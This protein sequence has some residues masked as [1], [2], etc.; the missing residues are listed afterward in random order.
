MACR[1]G[2]YMLSGLSNLQKKRQ[3]VE[4]ILAGKTLSTFLLNNVAYSDSPRILEC[5]S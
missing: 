2:K 5:T 4:E 3:Q 1:V